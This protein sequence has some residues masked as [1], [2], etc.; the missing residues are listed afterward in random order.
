M[1]GPLL[2]VREGAAPPPRR[3]A[4]DHDGGLCF[5]LVVVV[6]VVVVV[7]I[8]DIVDGAGAG[9]GGFGAVREGNL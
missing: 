6:V 4:D 1:L 9:A 5:E 3:I 2:E 8:V 7:D